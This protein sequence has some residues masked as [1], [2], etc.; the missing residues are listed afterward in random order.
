MFKWL[1]FSRRIYAWKLLMNPIYWVLI[2]LTIGLVLSIRS[3]VDYAKYKQATKNLDS[4]MYGEVINVEFE[5]NS[6]DISDRE[7]I[8]TVKPTHLGVFDSSLLT[9]GETKYEYKMGEFVKIYYD[10]SNT[11]EYYMEHNAPINAAIPF[12]VAGTVFTCLGFVILAGY[13]MWKKRA[14]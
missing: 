1:L 12:L 3:G 9:S 7:Y 13:K 4:E 2:F 5:E 11:S 10:S 6:L 8:A 14:Y